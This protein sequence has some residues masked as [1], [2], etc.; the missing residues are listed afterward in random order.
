VERLVT[1]LHHLTATVTNAQADLDHYTGLFGLRLVKKTV[2]FDNHDVYHFYY[3]NAT[4]A[5]GTIMTTFPYE[6]W[7][8]RE[9]VRGAGQITVTS[10]SVP[11]S[12]IPFWH[13]RLNA[14]GVGA[15][16]TRTPFGE[17]ALELDD[18]SG[19]HLRLVGTKG[20]AREPWTTSDIDA[21]RAIRGLHTVSLLVREPEKSVAFLTD[22]L[23]LEEIGRADDHIRM[24]TGSGGTGRILEIVRAPAD[25]PS[26]VNGLGTVHH[27]AFAIADGE[28]QRAL[29]D[30]LVRLGVGVTDIRDR[31]YFTSI[32]FR[33]PGGVLY[34]VATQGPGFA[35]DESA[36]ALGQ[37]LRLPPWEEPHRATI[38][39][40]LADV[41][42][43]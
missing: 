36:D 21:S 27:V 17:E 28:Q 25:A 37:A 1:G 42:H 32:Y 16:G 4:G 23:G 33:E 24:G 40:N 5:P 26:A 15:A 19:L 10:F 29:R 12:S 6:G 7:G 38:E 18:P 14:A 8:V 34:E 39:T 2:N 41:R 30:E 31:Q 13:E 20:D 3:G 35:I 43:P 11:E 9:G 22:V